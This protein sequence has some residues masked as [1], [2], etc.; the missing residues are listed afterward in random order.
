M[1]KLREDDLEEEPEK[2]GHSGNERNDSFRNDRKT[3][4]TI[5]RITIT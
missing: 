5:V 3:F 4:M 2:S 1:S